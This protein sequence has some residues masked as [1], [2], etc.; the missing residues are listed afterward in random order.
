[1]A[2]QTIKQKL[3]AKAKEVAEKVISENPMATEEELIDIALETD[4]EEVK[5][6]IDEGVEEEVE[7]YYPTKEKYEDYIIVNAN[8]KEIKRTKDRQE[9][10]EYA[11]KTRLI[12]R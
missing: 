9:A 8:G 1:M 4:V 12:I 3:D 10:I 2:K 5:K 6:I 11:K 7:E